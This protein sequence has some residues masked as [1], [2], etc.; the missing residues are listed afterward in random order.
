MGYQFPF[1]LCQE[2]RT[3]FTDKDNKLETEKIA[4]ALKKNYIL[5]EQFSVE[6]LL[7]LSWLD[8]FGNKVAVKNQVRTNFLSKKFPKFI[9]L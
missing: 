9:S 7:E 1:C 6:K 2:A 3:S 5:E 8:Q 4:W